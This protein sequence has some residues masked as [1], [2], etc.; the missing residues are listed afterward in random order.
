M[1]TPA[2]KREKG[3]GGK[4][5]RA[6][7]RHADAMSET[8]HVQLRMALLPLPVIRGDLGAV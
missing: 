6:L 1:V 2:G 5:G 3:D 4:C 8:P 7:L